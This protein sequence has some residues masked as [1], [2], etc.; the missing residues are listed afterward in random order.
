[1]KSLLPS[2]RAA[3][4]AAIVVSFFDG[5]AVA[6]TNLVTNGGFETGD[7]SGWTQSG[8]TSFTSV[9][10]TAAFV[11]S[12]SFGA[13]FGPV[14]SLGFISQTFATVVGQTY[15]LDYSLMSSGGTP[16][17]FQAFW[18]GNAIGG[19]A[20]TNAGAFSHTPFSFGGL[21]ATSASTTLTFGFQQNPSFWGFDNVSV[22]AT[23]DI[24][25]TSDSGS[26]VALLGLVLILVAG[27]RRRLA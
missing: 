3:A 15:Q 13:S 19:A 18:G 24:P 1:M 7:F 8:N 25:G 12:G 14:G 11:A 20:L 27:V 26:T 9:T 5:S 2:L 22:V 16:N 23:S 21:V 17:L 6:A 4:V 10:G